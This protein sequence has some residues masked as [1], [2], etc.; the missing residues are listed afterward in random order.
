[1][2]TSP[3]NTLW[4]VLMNHIPIGQWLNI[5]ALYNLVEENFNAFTA[6]DL[7]P[8][9]AH[10]NEPKWHRNLRNALQRKR[11]S[12]EILYDGN[13]NYRID[14]P[15]LWRMLKEATNNLNEPITYS[16]IRNYVLNK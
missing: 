12:G 9:T 13:A 15:Y 10:N 7:Q 6:D 4:T 16:E 1:M 2:A 14:R 5:G 3:I 11:E 8:V